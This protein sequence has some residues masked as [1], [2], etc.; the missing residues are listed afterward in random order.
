VRVTH[1]GEDTHT[2]GAPQMG[3]AEKVLRTPSGK[4]GMASSPSATSEI[5]VAKRQANTWAETRMVKE[6]KSSVLHICLAPQAGQERNPWEGA[7]GHEAAPPSSCSG[8]L[9]P[10]ECTE[11]CELVPLRS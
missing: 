5:R 9:A 8:D 2:E 10:P 11:C 3:G 1:A 6:T 4:A 7:C